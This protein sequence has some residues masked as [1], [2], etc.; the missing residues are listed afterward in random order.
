MYDYLLLCPNFLIST[1]SLNLPLSFGIVF[2]HFSYRIYLKGQR[3]YTGKQYSICL[4]ICVIKLELRAGLL[5]RKMTW[6]CILL[7]QKQSFELGGIS[8]NCAHRCEIYREIIQLYDF[9]VKLRLD[10]F[11]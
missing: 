10:Y 3:Q 8:K 9:D 6:H 4:L 7:L 1:W 2:K 11:M 5:N